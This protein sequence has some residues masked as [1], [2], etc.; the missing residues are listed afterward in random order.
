MGISGWPRGTVAN[1]TGWDRLSNIPCM[2]F[3]NWLNASPGSD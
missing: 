2:I 3:Q 1:A